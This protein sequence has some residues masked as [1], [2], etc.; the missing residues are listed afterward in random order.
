MGATR[1]LSKWILDASYIDFPNETV[2]CAKGL[3]MKSVAGMVVGSREPLGKKIIRYLSGLGG[4]SEAGVVGAGFRTSVENA[5]LA[6]GIFA[7]ASELEDDEFF[8]TGDAVGNYWMHPA[9]FPLAEKLLSSGREVIE[10][11][12]V[13]FEVASRLAQAVPRFGYRSGVCTPAYV[14]TLATT[15]AA[16]RM[17]DL[18]VEQTENA[19]SISASHATSLANQMGYDAHFIESGHSCRAGIL[20]AFLAE[21]GC[22]GM[23][24]I[25]DRRNGFYSSVWLE[26]ENAVDLNII[27]NGLGK[28]P[29]HVHGAEIKKWSSCNLTHTAVDALAMLVQEHKIGHEDVEKVEAEV[30]PV[31]VQYCDRPFPDNLAAARFSFSYLLGEVLLRGKIPDYNTFNAK[32]KVRDPRFRDIQSKIQVVSRPDWSD[33]YKGARVTVIKKNGEKHV[34]HLEAFLGHPDNPLSHKQVMDVGEGFITAIMPEK[35]TKRVV[36]IVE[37]MDSVADIRELMN[38]LTFFTDQPCVHS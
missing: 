19:L 27:T 16:A 29:F 18:S 17:L 32:E 36:E 23:P 2:D 26:D 6:A 37:T 21:A 8:P 5:A 31:C 1:E 35:H 9:I 34:K 14:G 15:A 10:A 4:T 30:N 13:S 24:E 20:S 33:G 25:L 22:N 3:I 38:I 12:I 7:H 28:P 11:I